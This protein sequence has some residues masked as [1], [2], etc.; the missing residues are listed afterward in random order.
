MWHQQHALSVARQK[1]SAKWATL[2]GIERQSGKGDSSCVRELSAGDDTAQ[3]T[4]A[5]LDLQP[6]LQVIGKLHDERQTWQ[7]ARE[8]QIRTILR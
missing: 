6:I 5:M 8:G 4:A 2:Q 3:A 7:N 1:I